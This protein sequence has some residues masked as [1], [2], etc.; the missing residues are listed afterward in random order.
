MT[1]LNPFVPNPSTLNQF[2]NLALFVCHL[3]ID[4]NFR[5]GHILFDPNVFD[6]ELISEIQVKCP[7]SGPWLTTD[8]SQPPSSTWTPNERT[9][10]IL[11]LIFFDPDD[12]QRKC[13]DFKEY[14]VFYRL[15]IFPSTE[16][17]ALDHQAISLREASSPFDSSSLAV[18]FSSERVSVLAHWIQS[19]SRV[20]GKR[21]RAFIEP[22]FDQTVST[23]FQK[24]HLFDLVFEKYEQNYVSSINDNNVESWS[25]HNELVIRNGNPF[26]GQFYFANRHV[27]PKSSKIYRRLSTEYEPIGTKSS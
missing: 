15:F 3:F 12:F 4:G 13:D 24:D 2:H 1:V 20:D 9:D 26:L 7:Q 22:I 8:V 14:F 17:A 18:H 6:S 21:V 27:A 5:A 19:D 23:D 10:K 25:H 16:E 11:Q